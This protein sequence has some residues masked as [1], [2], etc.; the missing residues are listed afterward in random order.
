MS[1]FPLTF[2]ARGGQTLA[3]M[4]EIDPR[5]D[6]AL[7]NWSD[8]DVSGLL[9]TGTVTLV[10]A[11]V[12]GSTRLWQTQPEEMTAAVARLNRVFGSAATFPE[13]RR[14]VDR[15]RPRHSHSCRDR[16]TVSTSG[17]VHV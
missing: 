16:M 1:T 15:P 6:T 7:V 4:S 2:S 9:P 5:A 17:E 3:S 11:D 12:E 13:W 10:L 14:A 8:L